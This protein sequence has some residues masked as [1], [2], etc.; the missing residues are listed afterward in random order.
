MPDMTPDEELCGRSVHWWDGEYDGTCELPKNHLEPFHYDG[1]S[2]YDDDANSRDQEQENLEKLI[3][4]LIA[5]DRQ[6]LLD[7]LLSPENRATVWV[8]TRSVEAIPVSV[9]E[10]FQERPD[11][12][13]T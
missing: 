8:D 6:A 13:G 1:V 3:M 2:Y 9:I 4:Q 5:A 7:R 12:N 11:G 10:K